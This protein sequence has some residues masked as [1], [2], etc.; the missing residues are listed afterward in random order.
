M[1]ICEENEQAQIPG[2]HLHSDAIIA[3]SYPMSREYNIGKRSGRRARERRK[4]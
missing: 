2:K 3:P 1:M 4:N